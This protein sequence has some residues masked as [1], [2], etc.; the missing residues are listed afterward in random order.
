MPAR[1]ENSTFAPEAGCGCRCLWAISR[2]CARSVVEEALICFAMMNRTIAGE[3][4][5]A[6]I[7]STDLR[8]DGEASHGTGARISPAETKGGRLYGRYRT[9]IDIREGEWRFGIITHP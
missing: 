1:N 3:T 4:L 5:T 2:A 7:Q 8:R 6:L 9:A